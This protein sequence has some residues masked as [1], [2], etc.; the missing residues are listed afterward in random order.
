MNTNR[1]RNWYGD[2]SP[3]TPDDWA[4]F[5]DFRRRQSDLVVVAT[6][7]AGTQQ[8]YPVLSL[9]EAVEK[10]DELRRAGAKLLFIKNG[11]HTVQRLR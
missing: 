6:D 5:D 10:F 4:K 1:E 7:D 3:M 2:P 11:N 9:V 8:M